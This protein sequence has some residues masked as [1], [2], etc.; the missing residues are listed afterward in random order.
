MSKNSVNGVFNA[1]LRQ[2]GSVFGP[3]NDMIIG[4]YFSITYDKS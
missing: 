2:R 4:H 1:S 3:F